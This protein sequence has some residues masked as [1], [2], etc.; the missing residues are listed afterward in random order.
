MRRLNMSAFASRLGLAALFAPVLLAA[1]VTAQAHQ[2]GDIIVRAGAVTVDPKEDSSRVK[3][4]GVAQAGTAATLNSDTQLGL[5]LAYMLS[6]NWAVE[7]LA[8]TPFEHDIGTKGLG[9]LELGSTKHLPPTVSVL[10]YPMASSSAFQPYAG[11]GINYT[12]MFDDKLSSEAEAAGFSGLDLD[13]S[14][15]LAAQLGMDY[16]LSDKVMLNAQIRYID[17]ETT[18]TTYSGPTKVS[19]DVDID[20]LVYMVGLGYKF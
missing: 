5:N 17:I 11:L 4:G 15:G 19:V 7:V 1:S 10:Y 12:W 2:A 14:W 18:G 3:V 9:G 6:D 16:M 8:A 13:D 20:P